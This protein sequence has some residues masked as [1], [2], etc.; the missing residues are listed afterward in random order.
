M[1]R[2]ELEAMEQ[3][4]ISLM[5]Y[6]TAGNLDFGLPTKTAR[7]HFSVFTQSLG[8]FNDEV[9]AGSRMLPAPFPEVP[10]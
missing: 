3:I 5:A 7:N 6:F 10:R 1:L 2:P 9:K 8:C 4:G